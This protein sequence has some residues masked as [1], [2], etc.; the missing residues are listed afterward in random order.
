MVPE[1]LIQSKI[2][3]FVL[4]PLD[5]PHCRLLIT[6]FLF[7]PEVWSHSRRH[8]T[9]PL[10]SFLYL[11]KEYSIQFAGPPAIQTKKN[12]LLI[13]TCLSS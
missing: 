1:I 13:E 5:K 9:K 10:C 6:S 11:S 2:S 12:T 4:P 3:K 7:S 8:Y